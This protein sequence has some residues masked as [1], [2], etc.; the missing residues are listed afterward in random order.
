M[1]QVARNWKIV[2]ELN[3]ITAAELVAKKIYLFTDDIT[4][5]P[6]TGLSQFTQPSGAWYAAIVLIPGSA[7]LNSDFVAE[8]PGNLCSYAVSV[9]G[10]PET[11]FGYYV[12]DATAPTDWDYAARFETPKSMVAPPD[13]FAFVPRWSQPAGITP[14]E[15]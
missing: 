13:G 6:G 2:D 9:G 8:A 10:T 7:F 11:V 1:E 14:S 5:D 15:V 12:A 3:A 4:P